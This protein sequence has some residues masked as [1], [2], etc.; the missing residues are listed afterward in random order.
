MDNIP[1]VATMAPLVHDLVGAGDGSAGI[2]ARNGHRISFWELT[3]YGLHVATVTVT[4]AWAYIALRYF[5][6]V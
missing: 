2:A 5:A 4:I 6:F 1:Y 3:K